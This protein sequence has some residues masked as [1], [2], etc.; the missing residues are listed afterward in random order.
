MTD[1]VHAR[2][3]APLVTRVIQVF[4]LAALVFGGLILF[5]ARDCQELDCLAGPIGIAIMVWGA[6]ALLSGLRGPAG[7]AFLIG[8]IVLGLAFTWVKALWGVIGL[9]VLS[10]LVTASK[11]RLAPYYRRKSK[12]ES[13]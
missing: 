13:S 9:L 7:F 11:D 6:V 2:P 3:R 5:D 8:A 12:S 4:G 1:V 10:M